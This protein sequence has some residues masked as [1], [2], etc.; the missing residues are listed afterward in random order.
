[1]TRAEVASVVDEARSAI[2]TLPFIPSMDDFDAEEKET[3]AASTI[4]ATHKLAN[5][6][7]VI[8]ERT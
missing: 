8:A 6:T 3:L 7:S 4:S 2:S 1:M 5:T